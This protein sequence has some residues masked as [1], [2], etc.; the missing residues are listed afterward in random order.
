VSAER[1]LRICWKTPARVLEQS[2]RRRRKCAGPSCHSHLCKGSV[3]NSRF[4]DVV[5]PLILTGDKFFVVF[6]EERA[7]RQILDGVLNGESPTATLRVADQIESPPI[8]VACAASLGVQEKW[9]AAELRGDIICCP[10]WASLGTPI[11]ARSGHQWT[12]CQ[13]CYSALSSLGPIKEPSGASA[14]LESDCPIPTPSPISLLFASASN[15][16]DCPDLHCT[17]V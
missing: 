3:R 15:C 16:G 1:A 10:A 17:T 11:S 4:A 8:V 6:Y 9:G 14:G 12:A 2:L 7:P 5:P 13:A